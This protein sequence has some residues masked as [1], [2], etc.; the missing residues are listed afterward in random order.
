MKLRDILN[1]KGD[2]VITIDA[3]STIHDAIQ[4]LVKHNIG[5]LLVLDES[6]KLIGIISERDILRESAKRDH[7]LRKTK[8]NKIMTKDVIVGLLDDDMDYT[9]SVMT[10]N[11]IRHLP[12]MEKDKNVGII[13]LADVVK[14]QLD[15]SEHDNRYLKQYMFGV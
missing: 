7:L 12:I 3:E 6:E 8:V 5:A 1:V 4:V 9:L 13:S 2:E 14:G 11:R 10:K 15:E